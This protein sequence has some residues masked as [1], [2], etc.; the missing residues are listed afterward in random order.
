MVICLDCDGV[1]ESGIPRGPVTVRRLL[2]LQKAGAKIYIVSPSPGCTALPFQKVASFPNRADNLK[3]VMAL[4][5]DEKLFIYVSDNA[6]EYHAHA[7]DFC[8]MHPKDFR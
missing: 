8:F 1:V 6:D 4:E 2:E 5:P 7:A 3:A